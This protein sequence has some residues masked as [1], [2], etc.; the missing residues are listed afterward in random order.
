MFLTTVVKSKPGCLDTDAEFNDLLGVALTAVYTVPN[1]HTQLPTGSIR[2]GEQS[3]FCS[4][5]P[6]VPNGFSPRLRFNPQRSL[7]RASPSTP[8]LTAG[9]SAS[10]GPA[11]K[12]PA[13]EREKRSQKTPTLR[14][15]TKQEQ[16]GAP[17]CCRLRT[18]IR[19]L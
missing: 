8:A 11:L 7:P 15:A 2:K 18:P 10:P 16:A 14:F 5:Q 3:Y 13:A 6:R 19:R 9:I 4:F 1:P 17:K 12:T